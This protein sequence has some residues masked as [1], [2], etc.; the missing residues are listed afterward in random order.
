MRQVLLATVATV[1]M[2]LASLVGLA[3]AQAR[4]CPP[5]SVGGP[6]VA[7]MTVGGRAVPVKRITFRNGGALVPP[8]T[9]QAAGIS[10]RNAPLGARRGA[11]VITWHVRFGAGCDGSLNAL[12]TMPIGSTFTIGATG[13]AAKTYQISS[14]VTVPHGKL[15]RSWFRTGGPH[16]LVLIT[17]ADLSGGV[18]RRTMAIIAA[19]VPERPNP[20]P[21]MGLRP[22]PAAA[23]LG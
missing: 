13:R 7:V 21:T 8:A 22:D 23:T 19:P 17:C 15:L 1:A 11:T 16:R 14:R 6:T 3:P 20:I 9:N 12:T 4:A 2:L 10:A 5:S 18:F